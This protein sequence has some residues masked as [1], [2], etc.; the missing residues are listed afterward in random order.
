MG[1][2]ILVQD[3]GENFRM[4]ECDSQEEAREKLQVL[5]IE[6]KNPRLAQEVSFEFSLKI[7]EPKE[8]PIRA[9]AIKAKKEKDESKEGNHGGTEESGSENDP[10]PGSEGD[11]AIRP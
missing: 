1:Y 2:L 4:V 3:Y 7:K 5:L 6:G 9:P 11:S 8:V 10:G